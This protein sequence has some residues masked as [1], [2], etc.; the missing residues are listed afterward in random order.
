MHSSG[1]Q[2]SDGWAISALPT[3][4]GPSD[5]QRFATISGGSIELFFVWFESD[6]GSISSWGIRLS[7]Y[8]A[9]NVVLV[10]GTWKE[11]LHKGDVCIAGETVDQL[12]AFFSIEANLTAVRETVSERAS[13]RR[14]DWHNPYLSSLISVSSDSEQIGMAEP[15]S[16]GEIQF[17]RRYIERVARMRLHQGPLRRA[18]LRYYEPVCDYCGLDVV[19]ILD[20]AHIDPDSEGGEAHVHNVRLLCANHHRALDRGFL[21]LDRKLNRIVPVAGKSEVLPAPR[22]DP[23]NGV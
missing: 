4:A 17:A 1:L 19:E 8:A 13:K 2:A 3:W 18:A 12:W 22:N 16:A 5:L 15:D 20:V 6:R 11:V 9:E 21:F 23:S 7:P 14:I 10:D